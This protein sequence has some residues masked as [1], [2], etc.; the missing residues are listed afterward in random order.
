M[1]KKHSFNKMP[2]S[3]FPYYPSLGTA[4]YGEEKPLVKLPASFQETLDLPLWKFFQKND[5]LMEEINDEMRHCHCELTWSEIN[6]KL[7]VRPA[8]TL[9]SH[10]P[11]I[12]TWQRD[13][14]TALSGIRS[15]YDVMV[16]EVCSPVWDIIKHE[17]GDDRVLIEFEKESLNVAGKSEDVQAISQKL[18]AKWF[19]FKT[20]LLYGPLM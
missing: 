3:V 18:E 1:A 20:L 16:F 6:G 11:S 19:I 13:A 7:T 12:K 2:L 14:S 10:R 15:K 17:L 4:L 8:A 9:V 5:H